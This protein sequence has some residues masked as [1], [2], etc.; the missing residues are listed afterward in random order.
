MNESLYS[1]KQIN[2]KSQK[3][4]KIN[5]SE[6]SSIQYITNFLSSQTAINLRWKKTNN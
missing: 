2:I 6:T 3:L 4:N 1:P 5:L